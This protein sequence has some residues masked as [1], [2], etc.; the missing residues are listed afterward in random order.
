MAAAAAGGLLAAL[1]PASASAAVIELGATSTKLVAPSCPPGVTPTNCRIVLTEVTALQT[2]RDGTTYPTTVKKAGAIVAFTLGL[3]K[4]DTNRAKAK[5]DIHFLD[6]TFGGTTQAAISVLRSTGPKSSR[7]WTVR[8]ESPV[9]HLQPYLGQVV[10]FP[11][12]NALPVKPGD[13]VA[14][15]VP[16]WAPVLTFNLPPTTFA[17]R[18]SRTDCKNAVAMGKAQLVIGSTATYGCNFPGTRVEYTAT[19][20]TSPVQTKNYVHASDVSGK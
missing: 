16:T 15:T 5:S 7:Q 18:Q 1:V 11:L 13:V 14:L 4:L 2:I 3:S 8:G 12:P 19:E 17:Y 6:T 20:V 10:Q 9:F